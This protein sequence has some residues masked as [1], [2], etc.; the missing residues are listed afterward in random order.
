MFF[1]L[2]FILILKAGNTAFLT[3]TKLLLYATVIRY[4]FA[5]SFQEKR[6]ISLGIS[7]YQPLPLPRRRSRG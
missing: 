2:F 3:L 5:N 6:K 4:K 7:S 1:V